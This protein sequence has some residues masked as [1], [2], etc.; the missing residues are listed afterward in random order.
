MRRVLRAVL[1]IPQCSTSA[2]LATALE[3]ST[4]VRYANAHAWHR[5]PAGCDF[6]RT[7][8]AEF[9]AYPGDE[10][11]CLTLWYTG[12]RAVEM[13][14]RSRVIVHGARGSRLCCM[15]SPADEGG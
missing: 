5:P 10:V 4:A 13:T 12:N 14:N 8:A 6:A 7:F 15:S 11:K 3:A 9:P 1:P 2:L